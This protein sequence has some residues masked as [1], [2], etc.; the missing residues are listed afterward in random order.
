M[1]LIIRKLKTFAIWF[2]CIALLLVAISEV[3]SFWVAYP[4]YQVEDGMSEDQVIEI[5]GKNGSL[6]DRGERPSLCEMKVWYGDCRSVQN[7]GAN[8]FL[9]FQLFFDTYAIV[10][11]K[12]SKVIFKWKGDA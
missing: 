7:S 3:F 12:N 1:N 11:F 5:F 4:Y 9:T 6:I 2:V 10:G 8:Y